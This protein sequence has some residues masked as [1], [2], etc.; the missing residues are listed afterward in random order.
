MNEK[1]K[2]KGLA[3]ELTQKGYKETVPNFFELKEVGVHILYLQGYGVRVMQRSEVKE[4][5][6]DSSTQSVSNFVDA[7]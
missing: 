5:K 6:N 4:F 1:E 7:I 3:K 2:T